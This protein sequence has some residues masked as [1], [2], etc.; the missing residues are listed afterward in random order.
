MCR[1]CKYCNVGGFLFDRVAIR[2][3]ATG[4]RQ[5][6][7]IS[8]GLRACSKSVIFNNTDHKVNLSWPPFS[9]YPV[10]LLTFA[11]DF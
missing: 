7:N 6:Q 2:S 4:W 9:F 5:H 3:R 8:S 1:L 10:L 11:L